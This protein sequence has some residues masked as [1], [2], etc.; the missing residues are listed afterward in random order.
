M[1]DGVAAEHVALQSISL[2]HKYRSLQR[3]LTADLVTDMIWGMTWKMKD[4][5]PQIPNLEDLIIFE[6]MIERIFVLNSWN[7]IPH[8]K[9]FLDLANSFSDANGRFET[10]LR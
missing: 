3:A 4:L 10:L 1:K 9:S 6:K 2:E 5:H 8:S 7:T